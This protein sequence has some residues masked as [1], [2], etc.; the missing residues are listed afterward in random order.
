MMKRGLKHRGL[1][2]I[3]VIASVV[4]LGVIAVALTPLIAAQAK[5]LFSEDAM[6]V[7]FYKTQEQLQDQI[8]NTRN[9]IYAGTM[10]SF[11]TITD[12]FGLGGDIEV[13]HLS[14]NSDSDSFTI[15]G[16]VGNNKLIDYG[17]PVI[18]SVKVR[19]LRNGNP[20][21]YIYGDYSF[22]IDTE[23]K[24]EPDTKKYL[25]TTIPE[26]YQSRPGFNVPRPKNEA[27]IQE[28]EVG[29]L[30]P[31][32]PSDYML[33]PIADQSSLSKLKQYAG[34]HVLF[35]VRTA[36]KT[37]ELSPRQ[38]Q[39]P[40]FVHG[41]PADVSNVV[42]I[43]LDASM[44]D[45]EDSDETVNNGGYT[46]YKW[47]NLAPYVGDLK[48]FPRFNSPKLKTANLSEYN[49]RLLEMNSTRYL[50]KRLR[51]SLLYDEY[52]VFSVIESPSEKTYGR[53]GGEDLQVGDLKINNNLYL[54]QQEV[55]IEDRLLYIGGSDFKIAEWIVVDKYNINSQQIN[56]IRKYLHDKYAPQTPSGV[57]KEIYDI[58]MTVK[59]ND[60][61]V[62]PSAAL[63]S[64]ASGE[65]KYVP[66]TWSN[67]LNTYTKG[68]FVGH[69]YLKDK[70]RNTVKVELHLKVK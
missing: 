64:M 12:P 54:G 56:T 1:T 59:Q 7:E 57:V 11:D 2:L 34:S 37:G 10:T 69:G 68:T 23:V 26:W 63:A 30:Y 8:I 58:S 67:T 28:S 16:V 42:D 9:A 43:H 20:V 45:I 5:M 44:V 60:P 46:V 51:R 61:F 6:T 13:V 25:L 39:P 36:A 18:K 31:A 41:L 22:K 21:D 19:N 70:E 48:K 15:Y 62:M 66:V 32:F 47:R 53:F 17:T 38:E 52:I 24:I 40:T 65:D 4:I 33:L 55:E 3:E 49:S 27:L 50:G 29:T 14:Q 35:T